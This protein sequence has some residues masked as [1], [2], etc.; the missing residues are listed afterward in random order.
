MFRIT[1]NL[2]VE[3]G[4]R[5]RARRLVVTAASIFFSAG[6]FAATAAPQDDPSVTVTGDRGLY[7]VAATFSVPQA[8]AVALAAVTDYAGIPRFMPEVKTSTVLERTDHRVIVEQEAV[9]RF[10]MFSRR[11]HLVLE[12]LQERGIVRFRDRCRKSF[13][14]YEGVWTIA[15]R[16]GATHV[17]YELSAQPS[18]DVPDFV[19]K[20]LLKRDAGQMI[21]RLKT[22]ICARARRPVN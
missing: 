13:A 12:V 20:R 9:A 14:R 7:T 1:R 8:P 16:D 17:T 10:M 22:E 11:V 4:G 15:E 21:Q 19:L 6:S 2:L 3:T 18:F 5:S